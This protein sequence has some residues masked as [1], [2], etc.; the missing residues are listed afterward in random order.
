MA[1]FAPE[2][3]STLAPIAANVLKHKQQKQ[4]KQQNIVLLFQSSILWYPPFM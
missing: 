2:Y 1:Q 3:S 4:Y